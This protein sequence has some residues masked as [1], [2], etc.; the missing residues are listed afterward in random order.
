MATK[1]NQKEVE[2]IELLVDNNIFIATIDSFIS[3]ITECQHKIIDNGFCQSAGT[4]IQLEE[5][6]TE[7]THHM[8][9]LC[10]L[11]FGERKDCEEIHHKIRV[12]V[13]DHME[14]KY[15]AEANEKIH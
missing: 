15:G 14:A 8:G 5:Q 9:S 1:K 12:I 11:F 4:C 6:D 10:Y 7:N 13:H 2:H 3:L